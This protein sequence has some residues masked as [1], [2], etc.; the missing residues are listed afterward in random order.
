MKIAVVMAG[1]VGFVLV[2]LFGFF[3]VPAIAKSVYIAIP[4]AVKVVILACAVGSFLMLWAAA[5]L[6]IFKRDKK[7]DVDETM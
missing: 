4:R 3:D 7:Q 6:G 5:I 1:I 2:I